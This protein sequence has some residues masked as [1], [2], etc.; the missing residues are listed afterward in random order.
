M[1][2]KPISR[3]AEGRQVFWTALVLLVAVLAAYQNIFNAPFVFDDQLAIQHN[4]TITQLWP[5]WTALSPPG[6]SGSGSAGRPLINYSLALNYAISGYAPWSYHALNL[7]IH[8]LAA[9]VLFGVIRR[10]LQQPVLAEQFGR[11]SLPLGFLIALLWAVHPLLT[12]TVT[13]VVQRTESLGALFYLLTIYCF[14]RSLDSSKANAWR[15]AAV[16]AVL[17]G[18][19]NKETVAT[20][21]IM[22]LLYDRT[23]AAGS[24]IRAWV[25][26]IKFYL[27]LASCWLILAGLMLSSQHRGGTVGF[28]LGTVWWQYALKQ[29]A[30]VPHYF[31]LAVWPHP[32]AIDYGSDVVTSLSTVWL[33]AV[34]LGMILV[35]TVWALI[36]KPVWGFVGTWVFLILGPSSSIVP[37][38]TQT[39]AEHRMYQPLAAMVAMGVA[40]LYRWGG[41]QAFAGVAVLAIAWGILTFQRNETYATELSVWQDDA[42]NVPGNFRAHEN[43]A[44]ALVNAGRPSEGLREDETSLRL[45]PGNFLAEYN[46]GLHLRDAGRLEEALAHFRRAADMDPY[47]NE[48]RTQAG[49]ALLKLGHG[50]EAIVEFQ[51]ALRLT[52][53]SPEA[54]NNLGNAY[55]S[56][57]QPEVALRYYQNAV[58]LKPDSADIHF[59]LGTTL[60][61]LGRLDEAVSEYKTCL[62]LRPNYPEAHYQLGL[63][64]SKSGHL[65]EAIQQYQIALAAAPDLAPA[66]RALLNAQQRLEIQSALPAP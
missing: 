21:P 55:N 12:E 25:L 8:G 28:G 32:L 38:T 1:T 61:L 24:F 22:V 17:V 37:L 64:L 15:V 29:C 33:P 50:Q 11:D 4:P 46:W 53:D 51:Q 42:A 5:P 10:T 52:P 54:Q 41:R 47:F 30:V 63:A 31:I 26:R 59:G 66:R 43:L 35:A 49:I 6:E 40:V 23:F 57:G 58:R 18:L 7:I 3:I 2:L 19:A 60:I 39:E 9:L 16:A 62:H 48:A 27:A 36:R 20:A 34:M 45:N 56:A 13:C 44:V 14:I 65:A